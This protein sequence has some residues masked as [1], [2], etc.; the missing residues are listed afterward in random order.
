MKLRYA[1]LAAMIAATS[2]K[3]GDGVVVVTLT[4]SPPVTGIATL[5][6]DMTVAGIHRTHDLTDVSTI[7]ETGSTT[8]GIDVS[9]DIGASITVSVE[10]RDADGSPLAAGSATAPI[11]GGKE[12]TI[13][14]PLSGSAAAS[15]MGTADLASVPTADLATIGDMAQS[16]DLTLPLMDLATVPPD[17][18]TPADLASLDGTPMQG[19]C[20][21]TLGTGMSAA[22]GRLDGYVWAVVPASGTTCPNDASHVHI[23]VKMSGSIY[24]LTVDNTSS[25]LMLEKDITLGGIQQWS[26]GWHTGVTFDYVAQGIHSSDAWVSSSTIRSA[27]ETELANAN[28]IS[29]FTTGYSTSGGHLI[30]RNTTNSDGAV[31]INPL[32]S[33]QHVFFFR[34]TTTTF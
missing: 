3:K 30:Q 1:L 18:S 16:Q 33:T 2:C 6:V 5:H 31:I 17:L 22:F 26:E 9:A 19:A 23:Q 24:D 27:L 4:A 12:S 14:I 15:D 21:S 20:T 7:D 32:S 8:F 13:A 11:D 28:H 10:A 34:F 25:N 29:I